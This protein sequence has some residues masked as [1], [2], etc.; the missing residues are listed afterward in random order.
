LK[1][2]IRFDQSCKKEMAIISQY[3][4]FDPTIELRWFG[5]G[6]AGALVAAQEKRGGDGEQKQGAWTFRWEWPGS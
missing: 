6:V 1:N 4:D 3:E 5:H 2:Y